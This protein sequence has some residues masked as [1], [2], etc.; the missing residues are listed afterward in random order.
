MRYPEPTLSAIE[1]SNF[2]KDIHCFMKYAKVLLVKYVALVI[3]TNDYTVLDKSLLM[4][5]L[6]FRTS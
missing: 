2:Y 3:L 1:S 4:I 5:D 6:D